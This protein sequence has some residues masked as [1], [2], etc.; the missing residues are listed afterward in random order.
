MAPA[1]TPKTDWLQK[2]IEPR[3]LILLLTIIIAGTGVY[4]HF[5]QHCEAADIHH[6][7]AQL[8]DRYVRDDIYDHD[9]VALERRLTRMQQTLDKI[10][11][12]L[13]VIP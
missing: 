13:G 8:D 7:T 2:W 4:W 1:P 9:Q 12:R 10:A 11:E 3:T 6:S 5:E